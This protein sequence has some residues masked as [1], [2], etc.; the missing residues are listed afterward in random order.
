MA[1][2]TAKLDQEDTTSRRGLDGDGT[3]S[4]IG[5][6]FVAFLW[7]KRRQEYMADT[8]TKLTL[9]EYKDGDDID[10]STVHSP[11][12]ANQK[13]I[14]DVLRIVTKNDM[15][16]LSGRPLPPGITLKY[17]ESISKKTRE[18]FKKIEKNF[19]SPLNA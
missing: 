7:A 17:V 18:L 5:V 12:M 2:A 11:M 15:G 8:T 4:T 9:K 16:D 10:S 14:N 1:T 6:G 13:L 19:A 3:V